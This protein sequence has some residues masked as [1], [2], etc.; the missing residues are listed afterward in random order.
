MEWKATAGEN[1]YPADKRPVDSVFFLFAFGDKQ[2]YDS[3]ERGKADTGIEPD[4]EVIAGLG[5]AGLNGELLDL[6]L[7]VEVTDSVLEVVIHLYGDVEGHI[8]LDLGA[9]IEG[10]EADPVFKGRLLVGGRVKE[11]G[12]A[13]LL[14]GEVHLLEEFD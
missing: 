6:E 14:D 12:V 4:I 3:A 1:D 9:G 8:E 7:P 5:I 11:D 13:V 2:H 10:A